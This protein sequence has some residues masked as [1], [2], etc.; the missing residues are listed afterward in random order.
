MTGSSLG[1]LQFI[2]HASGSNLQ[3]GTNSTPEIQVLYEFA[4]DGKAVTLID[5]PGFDNT[6]MS[7]ADILKMIG[8]SLAAM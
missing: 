3:I 7:D 8:F 4:L 1:C 2:N 5:T 6:S